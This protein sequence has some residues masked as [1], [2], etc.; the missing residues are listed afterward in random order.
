MRTEVY[1]IQF[2]SAVGGTGPALSVEGLRGLTLQ[3][4]PDG[5]AIG[6]AAF[7]LQ[8]TVDGSHW[9]DV[10]GPTGEGP[11]SPLAEGIFQIELT[12]KAIRI[13]NSGAVPTNVV[14]LIAGLN[15]RSA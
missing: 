5:G 13:V 1:P 2:S 8:G 12:L 6:G 9:E 11:A 3:I 15:S 14:A 10:S 4:S 7:K